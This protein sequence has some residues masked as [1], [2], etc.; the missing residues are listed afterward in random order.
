MHSNGFRNQTDEESNPDRSIIPVTA[1]LNYCKDKIIELMNLGLWL[2]HQGDSYRC[3]NYDVNK[4]SFVGK[5]WTQAIGNAE[6]D[7]A[8]AKSKMINGSL[9]KLYRDKTVYLLVDGVLRPFP[10]GETFEG[11]GFDWMKIVHMKQYA[12]YK[13]TPIGTLLPSLK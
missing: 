12:F 10:D 5:N 8:Q 2:P 1:H 7:I 11:M 9:I 13:L 3:S 6:D 4:T